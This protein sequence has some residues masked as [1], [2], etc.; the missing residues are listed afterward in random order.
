MNQKIDLPTIEMAQK[1]INEFDVNKEFF[2][3]DD[4]LS[5]L[6]RKYS[7][8]QE[9]GIIFIKVQVLNTL[10][11]TRIYATRKVAKTDFG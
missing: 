7:N 5:Y 10:Y 6:F 1:Y 4:V 8:N 11:N 9:L 3:T 2:T